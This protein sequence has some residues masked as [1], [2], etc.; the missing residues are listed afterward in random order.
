MAYVHLLTAHPESDPRPRGGYVALL[1]NARL[2]RFKVHQLVDDPEK[3]DL[4]LFS[5]VDVGRLCRDI[6]KHPYVRRYRSKCFMFG[7]DFRIIPFLPGIYT[8]IEKSWYLP[9]RSRPGFYLSC[10]INPQVKSEPSPDRDLLYSFMGD[11][12]THPVRRVLASVPH[13]RGLFVDTS[14]ESQAVAWKGSAEQKEIFYRRYA[15]LMK[16]SQFVLC[17]RGISPSS[18]RLFEAMAM[19]RVP[20]ILSDEWMPPAGPDWEKFSLRIPEKDAAD[21]PRLLEGKA[22]DAFEMG[23]IA[24]TE[25]EKNF[26]PDLI[27]H[28]VVELCLEIRQSRWLPEPIDRLS[29][30]PQLLRPKNLR[31]YARLWKQRLRG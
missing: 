3:A 4:I 6:L 31:E 10:L 27:F 1:E 18:I 15:D 14:G 29:I 17:P 26:S 9:N 28:K 7:T 2:D 16:R 19:G 20:V 5:E 24:R 11:I 23:K 13:P 30:I 21:V 22:V 25:W 12:Q 8:A